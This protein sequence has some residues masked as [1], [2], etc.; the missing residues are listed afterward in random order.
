MT[1]IV[2]D[3]HLRKEEPFRSACISTLNTVSESSLR[4]FQVFSLYRA[5]RWNQLLPVPCLF[6]FRVKF[7]LLV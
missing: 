4:H 5:L 7:P 3:L 1:R 6:S 2:G